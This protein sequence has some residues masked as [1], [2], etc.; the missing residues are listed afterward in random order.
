MVIKL[1]INDV[2]YDELVIIVRGDMNGDSYITVADQT[3][4]KNMILGKAEKTFVALKA[5]D[6]T[7]DEMVTV[8]DMTKVK[9]F[10]LGKETS[11]N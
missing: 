6:V 9:N 3:T 7:L 5:A 10:I 1:I 11:L 4:I 8:A 2:V